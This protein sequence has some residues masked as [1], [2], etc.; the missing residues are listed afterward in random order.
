MTLKGPPPRID[1]CSLS[2]LESF[3]T[4]SLSLSNVSRDQLEQLA[5]C[6]NLCAFTLLYSWA[7]SSLLVRWLNDRGRELLE[8]DLLLLE[9]DDIDGLTTLEVV[10]ACLRRGI[11]SKGLHAQSVLESG[12]DEDEDES[13]SSESAIEELLASNWDISELRDRLQQWARVVAS[14]SCLRDSAIPLSERN[15][16][17]YVHASAL[18][19]FAS[20][21]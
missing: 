9:E 16:S 18:G 20:R 15:I 2:S 12:T 6:H 10:D 7:P 14:V 17:L 11:L 3:S 4:G 19:I 13:E 21:K 1:F 5:A 8:D